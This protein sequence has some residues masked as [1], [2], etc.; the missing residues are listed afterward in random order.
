MSRHSPWSVRTRA[1][2]LGGLVGL[3][4]LLVIPRPGV[5]ASLVYIKGGNVWI[6]SPDGAR[7]RQVTTKGSAGAPYYSPSQADDG[8]IIVGWGSRLYRFN[9]AGTQLGSAIE[10]VV[11][12]S[13]NV[14][15]AGPFNPR[16]SPGGTTI[17]YWI[18]L[19]SGSYDP[20]CNCIL[21]SPMESTIFTRTD[22][23]GPIGY[24]RF[25]QTPS[26][27]NDTYALV[28]A[29]D[30]R[31]TPQVGVASLDALG[32]EQGWF[33]DDGEGVE[34]GYWIN[35][36][37]GELDRS[38]TKLVLVRGMQ[39]ERLTF[40]AVTGF[41]TRPVLVC[42]G[43]QPAGAFAG[44]TWSPDGTA[45]AWYENDGVWVSPAPADLTAPG[46]CGE[47]SPQLFIAGGSEPRWGVADVV[48]DNPTPTPTRTG[49]PPPTRTLTP[50]ST[51]T[52][53]PSASASPTRTTSPVASP[54]ATATQTAG[55]ASPT[56]TATPTYTRT[57]TSTLTPIVT[58]PATNTAT[59]T[60]TSSRTASR[61]PS[62]TPTATVP[63]GS[64]A[65][66]T[67][68]PTAACPG[69]CD[70]NELVTVDE[71]IR[72]INAL[73]G[74]RPADT[75]FSRFGNQGDPLVEQTLIDALS[76]ALTHC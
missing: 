13:P 58:P 44:P 46:A 32:N 9:Q 12:S 3:L 4:A 2:G 38:G 25:W 75:C 8:T 31:Q 1:P 50:S 55:S 66:E 59:A 24:S 76:A 34:G 73:Q 16:V 64:S 15:A 17:A 45:V 35:L 71:L 61:T 33:N 42:E 7:Q 60:A 74:S 22:G 68:P 29:P 70:E 65:T 48:L 18:G 20:G 49:T 26:W 69:D 37:D 23:S 14:Y 10:T 51:A 63:P 39:A 43:S 54:S 67:K 47:F 40:Y 52:A 53:T 56:T 72:G 28:F 19:S 27:I 6:A 21:T 57:P 36:D 11:S 5:A 62:A 41:P 30:N